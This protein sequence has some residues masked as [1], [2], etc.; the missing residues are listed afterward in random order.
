MLGFR[1]LLAGLAIA[2]AIVGFVPANAEAQGRWGGFYAGAHIGGAWTDG[3]FTRD[4]PG[5]ALGG[6]RSIGSEANG[7]IGGGHLGYNHQIGRWV[8][9]L[10][11][12]L[13]G[14]N[15][16]E[17]N[18]IDPVFATIRHSTDVSWIVTATAKLGYAFSDQWLGYVK[19]GYALADISTTT[20]Q[21]TNGNTVNTNGF[22]GGWTVGVGLDY[23]FTNGISLGLAYDYISLDINDRSSRFVNP[24]QD[25]MNISAGGIDIHS[26]T[27]RLT[28]KLG[29][30]D[31][32]RASMK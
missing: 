6:P 1:K 3:D 32:P 18:V 12:S 9:G 5:F 26:V 20:T 13:S 23:M 22:E 21:T 7:W 15:L 8:L 10:E 27:A 19:G 14:G 24:T 4:F 28:F 16:E 17:K 31:E 25:L 2:T 11:T 30:Y 29:R